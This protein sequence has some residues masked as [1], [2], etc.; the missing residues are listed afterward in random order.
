MNVEI[1]TVVNEYWDWLK[2]RTTFQQT[3]DCTVVTTPFLD[4]HNDCLE[5][6]IKQENNGFILTDNGYTLQDLHLSG[7]EFDTPRRKELLELS[8]R[9]F[10][11]E[12]RKDE[13]VIHSTQANFP[14]KKHNLVHAMLAVNDLFYLASSHV[15]S[16][17]TEDVEQWLALKEIRYTSHVKF[18]GKSG[19]D[20]LFDIIIPASP[21]APERIIK[22]INHATKEKAQSLAF[23]WIDIRELRKTNTLAFAML[24]DYES[25]ISPAIIDALT[26]YELHPILY[27]K[28][29]ENLSELAA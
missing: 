24:N 29:E 22:T 15:A 27:S 28:R 12:L 19:L 2:K 18:S 23:A 13:M 9:G 1:E 5:I 10:G 11:V 3:E 4:R 25:K 7:C 20:H 6:Y 21:N 26:G 16:L 17:F 8:I 14:Q